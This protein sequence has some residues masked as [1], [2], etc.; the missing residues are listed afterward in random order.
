MEGGEPAAA[1]GG[2]E[3]LTRVLQAGSALLPLRLQGVFALLLCLGQLLRH[4]R[5]QLSCA[6][7]ARRLL[8]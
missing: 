1:G 3:R 4:L 5:S 2:V 7:V 6:L 8:L